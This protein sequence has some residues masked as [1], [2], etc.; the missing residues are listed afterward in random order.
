[1][2]WPEL[3]DLLASVSLDLPNGVRFEQ[4]RATDVGAVVEKVRAWYPDIVVGAESRHLVPEFYLRSHYLKDGDRTQDSWPLVALH[5]DAIGLLTFTRD[6][7]AETLT[8]HMG[9]VD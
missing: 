7:A 9:V 8:T 2:E 1:M 3:E 6:V 4:L 5:G